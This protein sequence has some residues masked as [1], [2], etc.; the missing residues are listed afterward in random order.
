M[1]QTDNAILSIVDSDGN[2][3]MMHKLLARSESR[4]VH[5]KV[6]KFL[7]DKH[8]DDMERFLELFERFLQPAELMQVAG[9]SE[10]A[11]EKLFECYF[12][13]RVLNAETPLDDTDVNTKFLEY[14]TQKILVEDVRATIEK[15]QNFNK[16]FTAS[17]M[18]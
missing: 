3:D 17:R 9:M 18:E 7:L 16:G 5:A 2:R 15:V 12:K 8:W 10:N 4:G 11:C 1:N 13:T 14:M 6:F